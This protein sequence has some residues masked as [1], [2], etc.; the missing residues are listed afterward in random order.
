MRDGVNRISSR[1]DTSKGKAR[2]V[3]TQSRIRPK[4]PREKEGAKEK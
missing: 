4:E 2:N 3:R 1:L